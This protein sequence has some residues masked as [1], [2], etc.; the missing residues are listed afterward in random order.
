MPSC[1][2]IADLTLDTGRRL[3]LRDAAP[4]SLGPLTYQL[5]LTLVEAAPNVG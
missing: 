3:L 2:R 5:L 1:Y 4:I